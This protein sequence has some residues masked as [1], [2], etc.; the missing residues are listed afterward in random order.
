MATWL[1]RYAAASGPEG[2]Y[3]GQRAARLEAERLRDGISL[4]VG[5]VAELRKVG[6]LTGVPFDVETLAPPAT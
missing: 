6:E 5:V 4:T 3:P 2:R 1:S